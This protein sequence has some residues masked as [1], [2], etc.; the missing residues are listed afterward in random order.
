MYV[1]RYSIES[2]LT[3]TFQN[4]FSATDAVF[5]F[6]SVFILLAALL[7]IQLHAQNSQV[8]VG[9]RVRVELSNMSNQIIMGDVIR[10]SPSSLIL[11]TSDSTYSI[12]FA[13]I[14]RMSV[15]RET[16]ARN[17]ERIGFGV[18]IGASLGLVISRLAPSS[19]NNKDVSKA[20]NMLYGATIGSLAGALIGSAASSKAGES[21]NDLPGNLWVNKR[22]VDSLESQT[23]QYS[24]ISEPDWL[25]NVGDRVRLDVPSLGYRNLVG[26]V[27]R[28]TDS[29]LIL[30]TRNDTYVILFDAISKMEVSKGKIKRNVGRATLGGALF[31]A[32]LGA[33]IGFGYCVISDCVKTFGELNRLNNWAFNGFLIGTVSGA[34]VG[35]VIGGIEQD[36]WEKVPDLVQLN[37]K[38]VGNINPDVYPQVTLRWSIG[39]KK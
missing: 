24:Q 38:P 39:S 7:P 25:V 17:G 30:S 28:I 10:L 18:A 13:E 32:G 23:I 34:I 26:N 19:G 4:R 27:S 31:G 22:P 9:D 2:K 8:Q 14:K 36:R 21:W 1:S 16:P 33:G 35:R 3:S 37:M 5:V 6:M 29:A 12:P 20:K 11:A 15:R